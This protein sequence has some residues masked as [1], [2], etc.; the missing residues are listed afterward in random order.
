MLASFQRYRAATSVA[1]G[2]NGRTLAGS[3]SVAHAGCLGPRSEGPHGAFRAEHASFRFYGIERPGAAG[4][5]VT[6]SRLPGARGS[7]AL[8]RP[9]PGVGP[10]NRI[11]AR[12]AGTEGVPE[13][14]ESLPLLGIGPDPHSL[15]TPNAPG[16]GSSRPIGAQAAPPLNRLVPAPRRRRSSPREA[17]PEPGSSAIQASDVIDLI[18]TSGNQVDRRGSHRVIV[19]GEDQSLRQNARLHASFCV[20]SPTPTFLYLHNASTL[21]KRIHPG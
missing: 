14:A 18:V 3:W 15:P 9:S 21:Q 13:P 19:H 16:V 6:E 20:G 5:S 7:G 4:A 12:Q 2:S 17:R 11:G 10:L 1:P 8:I